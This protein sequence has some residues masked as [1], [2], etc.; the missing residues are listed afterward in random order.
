MDF[1]ATV[2]AILTTTCGSDL[3]KARPSMPLPDLEPAERAALAADLERAFGIALA[4]DDVGHMETVRDVLQCVRL[5]RWT[6]RTDAPVLH[7]AEQPLRPA[8]GMQPMPTEM[9][10][11]SRERFADRL[12]GTGTAAVAR[13]RRS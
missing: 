11:R 8:S 3:R 5:R 4:P 9:A 6:Q 10:Q 13:L 2:R 7:L 12:A 1:G